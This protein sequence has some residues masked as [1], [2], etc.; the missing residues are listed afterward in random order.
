MSYRGLGMPRWRQDD[1]GRSSQATSELN[2][3]PKTSVKMKTFRPIALQYACTTNHCAKASLRRHSGQGAEDSA[4]QAPIEMDPSDPST[5]VPGREIMGFV[6]GTT[7]MFQYVST[8]RGS[9]GQISPSAGT[10][11]LD[12]GSSRFLAGVLDLPLKSQRPRPT[13]LR[14]WAPY[15]RL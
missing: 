2:S 10:V 1:R 15:G 13:D 5:C 4:K 12:S 6:P 11:I 7:V 9:P 3:G 8:Y 14:L